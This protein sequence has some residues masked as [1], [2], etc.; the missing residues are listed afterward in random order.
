VAQGLRAVPGPAVLSCIRK[1][2]E[3][4]MEEKPVNNIP[5]WSL[6]QFLPQG[7]CLEFLSW[8]PSMDCDFSPQAA[9]GQCLVTSIE[10]R[11]RHCV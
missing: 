9:F 2:A 8:L 1:K 5:P 11:Q 6:L 10:S 3:M 4:V 7:S